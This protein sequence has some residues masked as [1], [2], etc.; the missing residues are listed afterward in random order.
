[1]TLRESSTLA[2]LAILALCVFSFW[3]GVRAGIVPCSHACYW[4]GKPLPSPSPDKHLAGYVWSLSGNPCM[5]S[6]MKHNDEWRAVYFE[7]VK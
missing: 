4:C 6:S 7:E 1:V 5:F 2:T 3:V